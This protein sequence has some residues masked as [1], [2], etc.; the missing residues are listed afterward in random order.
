VIDKILWILDF[1]VDE[2]VPPLFKMG[3]YG[4]GRCSIK[5]LEIDALKG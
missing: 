4:Y 3:Y 1:W 2:Q 5:G